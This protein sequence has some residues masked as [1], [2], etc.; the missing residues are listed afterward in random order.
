MEIPSK[1][2]KVWWRAPVTRRDRAFGVFIGLWTGLWMGALARAFLGPLPVSPGAIA[3]W[4]FATA[5]ACT[6]LGAYFPKIV[7]SIGVPF[8]TFSF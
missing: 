7:T 5:A 8:V 2:F 1:G 4:S 6:V 3:Q